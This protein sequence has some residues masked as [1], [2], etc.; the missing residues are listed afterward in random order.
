MQS[1]F[2]DL[3]VSVAS[4]FSSDYRVL[5]CEKRRSKTEELKEE[6]NQQLHENPVFC[7]HLDAK[8]CLLLHGSLRELRFQ[9]TNLDHLSTDLLYFPY[10]CGGHPEPFANS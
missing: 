9:D 2:L 6:T 5:N 3:L 7:L 8:S 1:I 10:H 4:N